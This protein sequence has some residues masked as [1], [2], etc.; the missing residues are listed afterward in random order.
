M[1]VAEVIPGKGD[2][3]DQIQA[4]GRQ[5][6]ASLPSLSKRAQIAVIS[7]VPGGETLYVCSELPPRARTASARTR[8]G[9]DASAWVLIP[10]SP[11]HRMVFSV[12]WSRLS[13][14]RCSTL[15]SLPCAACGPL[16]QSP[17]INHR[18]GRQVATPPG[19]LD[20]CAGSGRAVHQASGLMNGSECVGRSSFIDLS[21]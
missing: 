6:S 20:V 17:P 12:A 1:A 10:S 14:L 16:W 13:P 21:N 7:M 5:I 11:R 2:C 18:S 15:F 3:W 9:S 4:K 19:S 8:T